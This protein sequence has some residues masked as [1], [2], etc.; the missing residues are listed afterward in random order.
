M[1]TVKAHLYINSRGQYVTRHSYSGGDAFNFCAQRYYL[2][3]V[4]G[5][6]EK[7]QRAASQFGIALEHAVTFW[8]QHRQDTTAAVA[9]FQRL[10]LE[11]KDKVYIYSKPEKDWA[12]LG[13]TGAELVRLYA[14]RYP[15]LPYLVL[16]PKDAFQVQTN[17]EVFP[18]TKLAGIEF[19][20]YIDLMAN[21]KKTQPQQPNSLFT[22]APEA[23]E[24]LIID[25]KTSGKD[26]P[27]LVVLDPQLRSYAW[28]KSLRL[29]AFLWFRKMGREISKG[30]KVTLLENYGGLSA[31]TDAVVMGS[32]EFGVYVTTVPKIEEEMNTLFAGKS[33]A[34]ETAKKAYIV[35]NSQHIVEAALTKQRVQFK[36]ATITPES[37]DDIG[38]S[39]KKD[40]INIAAANEKE[41][42]P[43]Q[44]GVRFPNEKCPMCAMRGIC[45]GNPDLRDAL[46]TRKQ[47][48]EFDFAKESE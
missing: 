22:I 35:T 36:M 1:S 20:S 27:E 7:Q 23:G 8:H 19:T 13:K 26:I 16:N 47:L 31:G 5:W 12:S 15:T 45:S 3:R 18:G 25:I 2:E 14:I 38:R 33:K 34:V 43:M 17:F 42:W 37:A 21:I 40:V 39:I 9:E 46:V 32:D 28:V 6:S 29:V 44:S 41:F 48:D 11:H 10:W 30:D 4:Q 24:E